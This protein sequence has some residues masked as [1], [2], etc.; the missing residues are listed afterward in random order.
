VRILIVSYFFPP[1]NTIGAVRVG[2]TAKYLCRFGHDVRVLTA[3]DQP[4][5]T[6]LPLE[7]PEECLIS[8]QWINVNRPI[9]LALGGRKRVATQGYSVSGRASSVAKRFGAVYKHLINIPD[10]QI[11]WY[12]YALSKG[13]RLLRSWKPDVIFASAMPWTSLLVAQTL[14][15]E[16]K[17]PWI[18]ELRDLWTDNPY[19]D[20]PQ[21]R[22]IIDTKLE[23]KLLSSTSG[24]VTVSDPLAQ[25]L[26]ERFSLPVEV[27][28]N[29]FDPEDYPPPTEVRLG[30][31]TELRIV[32]T[33]MIY[34]GRRDPS[35]LFEAIAQLGVR[36]KSIK[37]SFY[38][39]YLDI[40]RPLAQHY[41]VEESV[42]VHAPVPYREALRIQAE[43]DMLLLLLWDSPHEK[44][45]FTGKLFE[46][47]G[48]RRPILAVGPIGNV[49]SDLIQSL[50]AGVVSTD[51]DVLANQLQTWL[52]Q[53]HEKGGIPQ[54][55]SDISRFTR[56][57]QT[58]VLESFL[59]RTLA[60]PSTSGCAGRCESGQKI[61]SQKYGSSRK[62]ISILLRCGKNGRNTSPADATGRILCGMC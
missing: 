60:S 59:S 18:A 55:C 38:G 5:P 19:S 27:V 51:P 34:P 62:D 17:I 8:T 28:Y 54:P 30:G 2:K 53:K 49:A 24:L 61:C 3:F 14:S 52:A 31:G 33:G 9:E 46:Y 26:L 20:L 11:G 22:R 13:R 50:Q 15:N 25:S 56:E 6:G 23:S 44:G 58:R 37:V 16:F 21:W 48:A 57:H 39:R 4:I 1:Y 41:G 29:G 43:A 36:A 10:G 35:P 42:E 47:L 45:T 40:V 12:P 32:Y 7:V